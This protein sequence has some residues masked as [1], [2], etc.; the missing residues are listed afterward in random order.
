MGKTEP[1]YV[2]FEQGLKLK[3]KGFDIACRTYYRNYSTAI[4]MEWDR[5]KS[6]NANDDAKMETA[7]GMTYV[8]APEQWMVVEW[9]FNT[10]LIDISS[11]PVK[12]RGERSINFQYRVVNFNEIEIQEDVLFEHQYNRGFQEYS[13]KHEAIS[14]GI[15]YVLNTAMI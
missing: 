6:Y 14:A 9:L 3:Q 2:T 1:K 5:G 13:S 12:H 15:D 7:G 8:S 4:I 10:Y 11:I